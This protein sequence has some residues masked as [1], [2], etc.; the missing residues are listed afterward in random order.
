M[1]V[2]VPRYKARRGKAWRGGLTV[3]HGAQFGRQWWPRPSVAC[4]RVS[5]DGDG[6]CSGAARLA[7]RG[8]EQQGGVE[9]MDARQFGGGAT[10]AWSPRTWPR[11]VL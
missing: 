1:A 11:V 7:K 2:K 3:G 6:E 10:L 8:R 9:G 4:A 5:T